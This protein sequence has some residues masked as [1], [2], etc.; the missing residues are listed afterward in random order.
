MSV[1]AIAWALEEAPLS[2]GS[3]LPVLLALANQ[4]DADGK[5]A[6]PGHA[7]IAWESRKSTAQV[8]K[9]LAAMEADGVIRRG[10]QAVVSYIAADRRPV[11]WDLAMERKRDMSKRPTKRPASGFTVGARAAK[12]KANPKSEQLSPHSDRPGDRLRSLGLFRW[13][14]HGGSAVA[15]G[16]RG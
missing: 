5:H 3:H 14:A 7:T 15:P 8:R 16:D 2:K 6:F 13:S 1:Q 11:V 9:D 10:N 12:A 4:A